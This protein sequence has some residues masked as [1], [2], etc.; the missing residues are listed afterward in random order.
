M[1]HTIHCTYLYVAAPTTLIN[2][3]HYSFDFVLSI[4]NLQSKL[5]LQE[6]TIK[7]K[8]DDAK[9]KKIYIDKLLENKQQLEGK[10]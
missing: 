4:G 2:A 6:R 5:Q 3:Y 10:H 7:I 1:H 8:E 9:S